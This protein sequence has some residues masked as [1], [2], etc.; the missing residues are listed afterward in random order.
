MMGSPAAQPILQAARTG[1][2]TSPAA[3]DTSVQAPAHR[4]IKSNKTHGQ[5]MTDHHAPIT[6]RTVLAGMAA[7]LAGTASIPG[8]ARAQADW[9]NHTVRIIVPYPAGGS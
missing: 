3:F 9:P 6:R 1:G 5:L 4:R 2:R 7:G 8:T